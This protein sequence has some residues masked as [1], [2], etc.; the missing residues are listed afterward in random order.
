MI[1]GVSKNKKTIKKDVQIDKVIDTYT[2]SDGKEHD[3]EKLAN[4]WQKLLNKKDGMDVVEINDKE[5]GDFII[6]H[7]NPN[8]EDFGFLR[9]IEGY[10]IRPHNDSD[11]ESIAQWLA[12][13]WGGWDTRLD[14]VCACNLDI[15]EWNVAIYYNIYDC[16]ETNGFVKNIIK[17]L[18]IINGIDERIKHANGYL[19]KYIVEM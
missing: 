9:F 5:F 16:D 2:T 17:L 13:K 10:M 12:T 15:G 3:D 14:E 6:N 4:L 19:S 18:D 1:D 8:K 11:A 7:A